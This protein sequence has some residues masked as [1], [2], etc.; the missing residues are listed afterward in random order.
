MLEI[1]LA[2]FILSPM[3]L[4]L[5]ARSLE[6][7]SIASNTSNESVEIFLNEIGSPLRNYF[8][9]PAA[10]YTLGDKVPLSPLQHLQLVKSE[11]KRGKTLRFWYAAIPILIGVATIYSLL[12]FRM[13]PNLMVFLGLNLISLISA[14]R[15]GQKLYVIE[16]SFSAK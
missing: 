3:Y 2:Y 16:A 15:F 5:V 12:R 11:E 1:L 10:Y 13:K 9:N 6:Y 7:H 8:L 14:W 4:S